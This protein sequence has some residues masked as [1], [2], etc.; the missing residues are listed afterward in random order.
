MEPSD[1]VGSESVS[2]SETN[3]YRLNLRLANN[4]ESAPYKLRVLASYLKDSLSKYGCRIS[5]TVELNK[6]I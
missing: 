4:L 3:P 6:N 5:V 1:N 2:S